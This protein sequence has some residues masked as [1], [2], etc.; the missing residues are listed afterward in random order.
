MWSLWLE[1]M[2]QQERESTER[3]LSKTDRA[4]L[5]AS[6]RPLLH[7]RGAVALLESIQMEHGEITERPLILS[8]SA[9]G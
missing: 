4:H 3:L 7:K 2:C 9:T 5:V 6:R 8:L 1:C